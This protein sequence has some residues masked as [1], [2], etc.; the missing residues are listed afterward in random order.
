MAATLCSKLLPKHGW[1]PLTQSVRH[2]SKAVTRHRKPLHIQKQK[3]LA[4]TQYIPPA[5]EF[6]PGAYPSQTKHVQEDNDLTL[7]MKRELKKLFEDC[8]MIAVVQNSSSS[9]EDM[10]TLRHRLY[11]HNITVKFFPNKVVRSFLSDSIY[12]NMG[13]LFVGPT[14]MFVSKEPKVKEML[15]T[16]RGSPQMTLLGACIDNTLLSAQGI[17]SYS[18][19]PS[20]TVIQGEVVSGLSMLTSHTAY[21][22]Q[23]HPAHLSQL[24]QQYIKQQSSDGSAEA[25]PKAEEAT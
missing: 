17:V 16:L 15:T 4:V 21:L 5:R 18:K 2:G 14:V 11:K 7:L 20:M 19:L 9:A 22:L 10:M 12:C 1:L 3:L 23:R 8:K 24:L 25:A 6:P 13:L